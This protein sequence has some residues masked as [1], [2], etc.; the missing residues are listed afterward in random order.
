MSD[1]LRYKDYQPT[2]FDSKGA[3]LPDRQEWFVAPVFRT[4]D[5]QS[6]ENSNFDTALKMLGGESDLVEVHRF[7]HWGPGWYEIILVFPDEDENI[8]FVTKVHLLQEMQRNLDNYP[9][10]D[11]EDFSQKET[12]A[13]QK[14]LRSMWIGKI[15]DSITRINGW[16]GEL[17]NE[18]MENGI[19]LTED[20]G[21]DKEVEQTLKSMD[22][23]DFGFNP[24]EDIKSTLFSLSVTEHM[25]LETALEQFPKLLDIL[26]EIGESTQ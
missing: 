6:L 7:G 17:H 12:D 26:T 13:I 16:E 25:Q 14:G 23:W 15:K 24:I 8:T 2:G 10:L 22:W 1:L 21:Y 3:F 5:S 19:Y 20:S 9:V 4:R 11:E 18:L